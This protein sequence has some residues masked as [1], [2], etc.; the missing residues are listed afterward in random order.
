ML[1]GL[2]SFISAVT[3]H[4]WL[5]NIVI[6]CIMTIKAL[7]S[8]LFYSIHYDA[9]SEFGANHMNP[10]SVVQTAVGGVMVQEMISCLTLNPVK[11]NEQRVSE[12]GF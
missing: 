6:L 8:I 3:L 2:M 4:C 12:Q 9:G 10:V 7:Y 11:L 5:S 1:P